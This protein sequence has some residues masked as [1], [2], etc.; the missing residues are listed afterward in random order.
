ML[1][2]QFNRVF[3]RHLFAVVI[4]LN[5]GYFNHVG[6]VAQTVFVGAYISKRGQLNQ[7]AVVLYFRRG[8]ILQPLAELWPGLALV[9]LLCAG[10]VEP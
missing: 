9:G 2:E 10:I 7:L 3:G 6:V 5:T 1:F 4:A 8:Q